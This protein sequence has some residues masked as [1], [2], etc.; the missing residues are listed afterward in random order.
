MIGEM[1][2]TEGKVATRCNDSGFLSLESAKGLAGGRA[3]PFL[4]T[5]I[6]VFAASLLEIAQTVEI[7]YRR[8]Q[9]L[10]GGLPALH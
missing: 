8:H 5:C 9:R 3:F 7:V 1:I 6:T 10:S 4:R 2:G